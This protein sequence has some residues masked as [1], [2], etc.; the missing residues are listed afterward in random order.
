MTETLN[1]PPPTSEDEELAML[2][3]A[4]EA[5]PGAGSMGAEGDEEFTVNFQGGGEYKNAIPEGIYF[6]VIRDAQ[7]KTS[8][9]ST[10]VLTGEKTGGNK[11]FNLLIE[12]AAGEHKGFSFYDRIMLSGKSP[13]VLQRFHILITALGQYDRATQRWTGN[14]RALIG[15]RVW[16]KLLKKDV[17]YPKGSGDVE[18]RNEVAYKGY[19]RP[20]AHAIPSDG[21][22]NMTIPMDEPPVSPNGAQANGA[23]HTPEPAP[24]IATPPPAAPTEPLTTPIPPVETAPADQQVLAPW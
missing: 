23:T 3:R 1:A 20:D 5:G 19:E 10:D 4:A 6:C 2:Q 9:E 8:Q 21:P 24:P 22:A 17:E 15:G 13:N 16:V 12:V 14:R 18:P 11:Y 7:V